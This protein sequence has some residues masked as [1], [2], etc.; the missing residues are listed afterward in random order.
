MSLCCCARQQWWCAWQTMMALV[1]QHVCNVPFY[2]Y[3]TSAYW[4]CVHP[5]VHWIWPERL[6][7]RLFTANQ[8]QSCV[9]ASFSVLC[10]NF[11]LNAAANPIPLRNWPIWG[12]SVWTDAE[13]HE[14]AVL[15]FH[16]FLR[17]EIFTC[18]ARYLDTWDIWT[19]MTWYE[20]NRLQSR[21]VHVATG[22]T[23]PHSL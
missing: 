12:A 9:Y 15:H 22:R 11:Y 23:R 16:L 13:Q 18:K 3:H 4:A 20:D 17:H 19:N 14:P 21:F 1:S 2:A 7:V 5:T 6:S 10:G 8:N